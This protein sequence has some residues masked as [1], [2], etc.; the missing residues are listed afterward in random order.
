MLKAYC[1]LVLN[2]TYFTRTAVSFGSECCSFTLESPSNSTE[3]LP[4]SLHAARDLSVTLTG[5]TPRKETSKQFS[6]A[7]KGVS[8]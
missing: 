2:H 4:V 5:L 8:A 1:V 3:Q 6:V 7:L